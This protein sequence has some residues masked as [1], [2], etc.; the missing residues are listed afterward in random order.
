M[1]CL[2]P[3]QI[4][5]LARE[6]VA[7]E[8]ADALRRH[9]EQCPECRNKLAQWQ[10]DAT[11]SRRSGG[12]P[13]GDSLPDSFA[14]YQ[15]IREIHRGGQGVIY[16]AVQK[17]TKRKVA[18]KVMK[19]GPFAGKHD[20]ARFEREVEVLGQLNHPNIVTIHDSGT[21]AGSFYFVM[22]YISGQPLD[23]WMAS[24]KRSI[25]ETLR[26]FAKICDAVNAAH[27]R[28]VIHRDLKPGN[29]RV[30]A[31]GEPHVLD[32]GLAKVAAGVGEVSLMTMTGQFVGS[33]PWAS[34]EQAEG[35]PSKIDTRT[36][37]YSL[38]VVLYQML[39]GKFPYEVVGNMR[40][41]LDRIMR[42][43]PARPSTVR[44][45]I[46]DEV[47]TIVLKCLSKERERRYQ[48]AGELA[49][50]IGHY[51]RDE[52]IEAKRDS[53]LYVLRKYLRRYRAT[54]AT[55]G[56]L[57]A[58]ISAAIVLSA[59]SL[60][61]AHIA[62]IQ[63]EEAVRQNVF[64]R[65]EI[66]AVS[67]AAFWF[68][69]ISEP[70]PSGGGLP[71]LPGLS[72]RAFDR[73]ST[74]P[75]E[76]I[77]SQVERLFKDAPHSRGR[78]LYI[79][80]AIALADGDPA[81]Q[82]L[83]EEAGRLLRETEDAVVPELQTSLDALYSARDLFAYCRATM[84]PCSGRVHSFEPGSV[85]AAQA[86][87]GD[88][89]SL[90][91]GTYDFNWIPPGVIVVGDSPNTTSVTDLGDLYWGPVEF[92]NVTIGGQLTRHTD[93]DV[94]G[95]FVNCHLAGTWSAN[96]PIMLFERCSF[97]RDFQLRVFGKSRVYFYN[98]QW[99]DGVE[100]LTRDPAIFDGA[101]FIGDCNISTQLVPIAYY[102]AVCRCRWETQPEKWPPAI[103]HEVLLASD[104]RV[105][106]YALSI[107]A[108]DDVEPSLRDF[109]E[110]RR[111]RKN[112]ILAVGVLESVTDPAR[113][114]AARSLL[115]ANDIGSLGDDDSSFVRKRL[116]V[117]RVLL[118]LIQPKGGDEP[119][120]LWPRA[121]VNSV[122]GTLGEMSRIKW[123]K[124]TAEAARNLE[125]LTLSDSRRDDY[126]NQEEA[127]LNRCIHTKL[128]GALWEEFCG[129]REQA[130]RLFQ[131]VRG[132]RI[133]LLEKNRRC[134]LTLEDID[135]L[136]A[137]VGKP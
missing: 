118:G 112:P 59:S 132:A 26:L 7:P 78:V 53:M 86:R 122:Y 93:D 56:A 130:A 60:S 46:N 45:Q 32:F 21:A 87:P 70:L 29:I 41:V 84:I 100:H 72:P 102:T 25:E 6:A 117:Q 30:D 126:E 85:R 125:R 135:Q 64:V 1:A 18:I 114:A 101:Q 115:E 19:E 43:E 27:L 71:G 74:N 66:E 35:V 65:R 120:P 111:L 39:T 124:W 88:V 33:L 68:A 116:W 24:G 75:A 12:W 95:R 5:L 103:N 128:C 17:S 96:N 11:V 62:Q 98:C 8:E 9:L 55:I 81:A 42:A 80:G 54:V 121:E 50:D 52:P 82:E 15:I 14:G 47:E 28:G 3:E 83:L 104:S 91:A 77:L 40:D 97:A 136:A 44:K 23:V 129:D 10:A 73:S 51:L 36:D 94:I 133:R 137:S 109:V 90:S 58:V 67:Q 4:E 134:V 105:L 57:C 13:L 22:D 110:R 99:P 123:K 119:R 38:G 48:T 16:Q 131:G 34:P 76:E 2:T 108:E 92:H 107:A 69:R 31:E 63:R 89:L 113:R 37:V 49:R 127:L 20:K 79:L 61:R 106:D